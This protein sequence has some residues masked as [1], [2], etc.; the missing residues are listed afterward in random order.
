MCGAL[1]RHRLLALWL[2]SQA[3]FEPSTRVLQ[4]APER[5]LEAALRKQPHSRYVT[6]DLREGAA[7]IEADITDLPFPDESFDVVLCNHVLEHVP[8]DRK[9]VSEL[10]RVLRPGGR[11]LMMHPIDYGREHTDEDPGLLDPEERM[12]RFRQE[13]HVRIYGR[14]FPARLA[15]AGFAVTMERFTD[16]LEPETIDRFGLTVRP[17]DGDEL[18]EMRSD[19]IYVCV[20][21]TA[22]TAASER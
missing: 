13:D 18:P 16:D 11:A 3:L 4:M 12:R 14:D 22:V 9:A 2:Q 19:D 1:E 6:A 21:P 5:S 7:E 17:V 15:D 8:D 20:R 10:F